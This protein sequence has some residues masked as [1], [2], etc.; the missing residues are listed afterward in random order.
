MIVIDA[1][2][3]VARALN[4]ENSEHADIALS[5]AADRGAFVPGNFQT[6]VVNAIIKA[7]RRGRLDELKSGLILSEIAKLPLQTVSPDPQTILAAARTH[8]LTAYDAAYLALAMEKRCPLATVDAALAAA[9]KK[10]GC[11][12]KPS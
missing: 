11:Q 2:T 8:G 10:A 12:W 3:V 6:E 9:A 1:S 5:Y 7:E 4:D